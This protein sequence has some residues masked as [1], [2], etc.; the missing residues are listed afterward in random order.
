MLCSNDIEY[1]QDIYF[2]H[3]NVHLN[4]KKK[5]YFSWINICLLSVCWIYLCKG[6]VVRDSNT[7]P[8]CEGWQYC[9]C[10]AA[11]QTQTRAWWTCTCN[12]SFSFSFAYFFPTQIKTTRIKNTPFCSSE[13]INFLASNKTSFFNF[14]SLLFSW[15]HW[16]QFQ[17]AP[18]R[19]RGCSTPPASPALKQVSR[20]GELE[21]DSSLR[22]IR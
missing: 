4:F 14:I 13:C 12:A 8:G 22:Y 21:G 11:V 9:P 20:P 10:N 15:G 16:E 19:W 7:P 2:K 18:L 17:C 5:M 6:P 3:T 1:V